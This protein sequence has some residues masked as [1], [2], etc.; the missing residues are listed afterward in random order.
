MAKCIA[1]GITLAKGWP[2]KHCGEESCI[3]EPSPTSNLV[4]AAR[5]LLRLK[6]LKADAGNINCSGSWEAVHRRDAMWAE[7]GGKIGGAW[8]AL[9]R[10]LHESPVET[11]ATRC[12][13]GEQPFDDDTVIVEDSRKRLHTIGRCSVKASSRRCPVHQ[14]D[15]SYG[16]AECARLSLDGGDHG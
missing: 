5:E 10:A 3:Q 15:P 12:S 7:Y 13:C 11:K 8:D 16:C 6:D 14:N 4:S 9:R 1:C 2:F